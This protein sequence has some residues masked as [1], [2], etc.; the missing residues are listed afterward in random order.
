MYAH[1]QPV[2]CRHVLGLLNVAVCF[3]LPIK[4]IKLVSRHIQ[5]AAGTVV[6]AAHRKLTD[7]DTVGQFSKHAAISQKQQC[8]F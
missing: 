7:I 2:C 1:P 4:P 5:D 6:F 3:L 8:L